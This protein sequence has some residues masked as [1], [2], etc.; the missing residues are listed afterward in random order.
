MAFKTIK[1]NVLNNAVQEVIEEIN[2][3]D[4]TNFSDKE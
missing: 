3:H 2:K 1:E 4:G